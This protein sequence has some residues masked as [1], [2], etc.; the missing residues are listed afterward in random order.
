MGFGLD[1]QLHL[2]EWRDNQHANFTAF[3]AFSA[4]Y[5]I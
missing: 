1:A 2:M 4:F 3:Q 5:V